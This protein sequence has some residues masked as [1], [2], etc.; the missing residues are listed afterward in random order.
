MNT[1][2]NQSL[3]GTERQ[4]VLGQGKLVNGMLHMQ[5]A[6]D[7]GNREY[8]LSA[9]AEVGSAL[10][11]FTP[12]VKLT[13]LRGNGRPYFGLQVSVEGDGSVKVQI[14][15]SGGNRL[16]YT[17]F[18]I[19]NAELSEWLGSVTPKQVEPV[20]A[21]TWDDEDEGD[22]DNGGSETEAE[23]DVDTEAVKQYLNVIKSYIQLIEQAL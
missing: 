2:F 14:P 10:S 5:F 12:S 17:T 23:D 3:A 16:T 4:Y 6:G 7:H 20:K 21:T 9:D 11:G 13:S 18:N 15:G 19:V 22:E 8:G 1:Q